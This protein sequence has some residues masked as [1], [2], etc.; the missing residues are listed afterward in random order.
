MRDHQ[1][2][3]LIGQAACD[4]EEFVDANGDR[5]ADAADG[6]LH[7]DAFAIDFDVP[8]AAVGAAIARVEGDG[9]R[10][11]VGLRI[12]ARPDGLHPADSELTPHGFIS[13]AGIMFPVDAGTMPE[14]CPNP[15]KKAG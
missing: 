11:R 14:P 13:H 15:L 7:Q 6:T 8:Y 3:T 9:Q 1:C 12:A 2:L 4:A 10:M 5:H